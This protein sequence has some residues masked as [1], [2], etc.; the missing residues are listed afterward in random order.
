MTSGC[1]LE[2]VGSL[3][4]VGCFHGVRACSGVFQTPSYYSQA[5]HGSGVNGASVGSWRGCLARSLLGG[6][7]FPCGVMRWMG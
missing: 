4:S 1:R 7:V 2:K 3:R 6:N 5:L